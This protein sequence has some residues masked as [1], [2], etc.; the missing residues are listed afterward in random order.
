MAESHKYV[1]LID[2]DCSNCK[3]P[4]TNVF[5]DYDDDGKVIKEIG[6]CRC[7]G[8]PVYEKEIEDQS[9][10]TPNIEEYPYVLGISNAGSF[11]PTVKCPYCGST[12]TKKISTLS[13]LGSFA[14]FGF[15]GKKVGKQWHCNNCKSDF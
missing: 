8:S 12:S 2:M 10:I 15:A 9:D 5:F 6:E 4:L 7:C 11:K 1:G 14:T 3:N 13:R